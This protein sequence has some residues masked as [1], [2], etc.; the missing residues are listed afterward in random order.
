MK[1]GES[2]RRILHC[3]PNMAGGGAERQCVYL[4]TGLARRGWEVHVALTGEGPNYERI[5]CSGAIIHLLRARGSHDP[6]LLLQ[7]HRIVKYI[8]PQILQTWL[9]QM[10]ILG[11]VCATMWRIP[12][13]LSERC[14][15]EAYPRTWKNS[16]RE[17]VARCASA[18]VSNSK[19]GDDYWSP[20]ASRRTSR[21]IIPNGI[22]FA[23]IEH[24]PPVELEELDGACT[25]EL[26]LCGGRHSPQKNIP[27]LLMALAKVLKKNRRIAVLCGEGYGEER[28]AGYFEEERTRARLRRIGHVSSLWGWLRHAKA[29]VSVSL[30]EGHPNV[31]LEAMACGCPVVVS[32]IPAHRELLDETCAVFVK[33]SDPG[34]IADGIEYCLSDREAS[35]ARALR[36]W[37]KVQQWSV[38]R[39]VGAYEG[40]YE[41]ILAGIM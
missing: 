28:L 34:S 25:D 33:P 5:T 37:E 3:I 19:G 9:T 27:A 38:D 39:M 2:I 32:D 35:H 31:V 18:I 21:S 13:I 40:I 22:P 41:G 11:G 29:F 36:A 16:L 8:Q 30:F 26:V 7:L 4:A 24:A 1:R 12:W 15:A 10:D 14:C 6:S 23:E 17:R 20:R